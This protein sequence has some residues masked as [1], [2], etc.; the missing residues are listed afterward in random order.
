MIDRKMLVDAALGARAGAYSP[1]S[2]FCV[3]A[4][5]LCADGEV[6]IGANVE[7][8]SYGG[9]IC[10]ERVALTSAVVNGKRDF[11]AIA[12]V[13]APC[14]ESVGAYCAP[15]GICRQFMAEFCAG[16][17]EILLFDGKEIKAYTLDALF[18]AA[19]TKK[20]LEI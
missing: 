3:G 15:C 19:F 5:L 14:G 11:K 1:Y 12:I 17:F 16:D 8:S 9:T 13:G 7:N 4:A 20:D 2:K 18:P 6:V 10:A